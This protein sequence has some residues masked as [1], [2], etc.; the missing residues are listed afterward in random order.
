MGVT[1]LGGAMLVG[2]KAVPVC[3]VGTGRES[4]VS[5]N[6]LYFLLGFAVNLKLL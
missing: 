5:G 4:G 2:R 1:G 3:V 6:C